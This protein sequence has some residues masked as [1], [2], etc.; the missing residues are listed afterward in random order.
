LQLKRLAVDKYQ[1]AAIT[2]RGACPVEDALSEG[3]ASTEAWR[4]RLIAQLQDISRLGLHEVEAI[5]IKQVHK[6][7]IYELKAGALR[8]FFF[9]GHN[10]MAVI[11]C[12][13]GRKSQNKVDKAAV[14]AALV[15]KRQYEQALIDNTLE[16]LD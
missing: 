10:N 1:V 11:C 8:L 9:K 7:G 5:W 13:L 15:S 3:E 16:Y 14:A 12:S 2:D 4:F 6:D